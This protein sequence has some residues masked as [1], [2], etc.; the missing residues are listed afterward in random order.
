MPL[1]R[2]PISCR[3]ARTRCTTSSSPPA[4]GPDPACPHSSEEERCRECVAQRAQ[5]GRCSA[6]STQ[7]QRPPRWPP[8][9]VYAGLRRE[10][11]AGPGRERGLARLGCQGAWFIGGVEECDGSG[12]WGS[13]CSCPPSICAWEESAALH[14]VRWCC[15]PLLWRC[16]CPPLPLLLFSHG[17]VATAALL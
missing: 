15:S 1:S 9:S 10:S 2:S 11:G 12:I 4:G 16:C 7:P 14:C 3:R 6:S 17:D 13:R 8:C 5:G